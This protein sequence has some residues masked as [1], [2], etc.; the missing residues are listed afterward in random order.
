M[1]LSLSKCVALLVLVIFIGTSVAK[2]QNIS[3]Y[4]FVLGSGLLCD[5]SDSTCSATA[6]ATRGD[7]YEFSG[8]G[9]FDAQDKSVKAAGTFTHES[10]SAQVLETGVWIA[11]DLVSFV[12]YGAAPDALLRETRAFRPMQFDP[13]HMRI[14]MLSG[15]MPTGGLAVLR[16]RLLSVSGM[17]RNAVLKMNCS[18]GDVPS[19]HSVEGVQLTIDG[20]GGE[21][22]EATGGRVMFLAMPPGSMAPADASRHELALPGAAQRD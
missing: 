22:S 4:T 10:A 9:S 2:A 7:S 15:P 19:E 8:A 6:R 3:S 20:N 16:I 21:Y 5:S 18:L 1:Y 13:K 11:S 17:P 14:R 12:S